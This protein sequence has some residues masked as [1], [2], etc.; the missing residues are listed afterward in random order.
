MQDCKYTIVIPCYKVAQIIDK[1]H[2][3]YC[4]DLCVPYEVIFVDDC[5]PDN[6]YEMLSDKFRLNDNVV[7]VKTDKNGG[8]GVAR[9]VGLQH[10]TGEYVLFC[11]SDDECDLKVLEKPDVLNGDYDLAVSP[12]IVSRGDNKKTVDLYSDFSDEVDRLVVAK[13]DG[14]PWGKVFKKSIIDQNGI[15]FPQRMTGEDKVFVVN[16]LVH[17]KNIRKISEPFYTYVNNQQSI[18]HKQEGADISLATTFEL[19]REI[20]HEHFPE[21]EIEM[22]VNGHLMTRAK[23]MSAQKYSCKQIREWFKKENTLYPDWYKTIEKSGLSLYRKAIYKAMYKSSAAR[24]K[25]LMFIRK[26]LH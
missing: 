6:S 26:I 14:N 25:L 12:Y 17:S 3:M 16:Y 20:Y 23:Q 21:I 18:S 22:F 4:R 15:T 8:P 11:D 2:D 7:V 1:L 5:S 24:I 9:N 13:N 19:L 10:A